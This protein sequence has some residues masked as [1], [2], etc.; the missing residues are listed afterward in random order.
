MSEPK[1]L[2]DLL[3]QATLPE[4][5]VSIVMDRG[6]VAEF[7]ALEDDLQRANEAK[8]SDR[9]KGSEAASI[10]RKIEDVREKMRA[11]TVTFKLR[12]MR[13]SDWRAMKA[14][15]PIKSE[16]PTPTERL[17]GADVDGLL[18]EAVRASII[19]PQVDDEDWTTLLD[20]LTEGEW[21]RFTDTVF[22]LNEEGTAI[23]F[24][25]ASFAARRP[26]DDA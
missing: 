1:S 13:G 3:K 8:L 17:F 16:S 25:K 24:S 14:K 15:H 4:R 9:R 22:Q 26:N 7:Q 10:S 19:E 2:K 11:S 23:P 21:E 12:G 6:L 20:V 5:I 18:N